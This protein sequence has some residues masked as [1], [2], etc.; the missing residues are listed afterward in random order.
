MVKNLIEILLISLVRSTEKKN[1]FNLSSFITDNAVVSAII[2]Y[3]NDNITQ[4][5][6]LKDISKNIGY[7]IPHFSRIFKKNMECSVIEYLIRL[8]ILKA[9]ELIST[10]DMLIK[11][12]SEYLAFDSI[13]YFS[14]QFKK[15]TGVS[16]SQ[17]KTLIKVRNWKF[18]I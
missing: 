10:G 2:G 6:T 4:K 17:Y 11:D 16:P 3:M 1:Q 12:I 14:Y 7:S 9:K 5:I 8:K 13:Q 15:L 18:D